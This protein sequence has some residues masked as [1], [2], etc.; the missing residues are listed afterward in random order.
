MSIIQQLSS[1]LSDQQNLDQI[2]QQIGAEPQQ[3]NQAISSAIPFIISALTKNA[4]SQQGA[5]SLFNAIQKD[6]NGGLLDNLAQFIPMF[7][8]GQ[9]DGI[10]RHVLGDDRPQAE[11]G[12]SKATGLNTTQI[13][14]LLTMLAPI[15]MGFLGKQ[16]QQQG[17]DSPDMLNQFL[18][19]QTQQ[20][21]D[22]NGGNMMNLISGMLDQNRD[23]SVADDVM[24]ML[25]KFL[26]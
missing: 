13:G 24:G 4:S 2:S 25:G 9:G 8:Q 15:V 3:T 10:L 17:V 11:Q 23:G 18:Q 14:S 7:T 19:T 20:A 1:L 12:L 6:H 16:Q 22:Q 5:E 21:A 26:K